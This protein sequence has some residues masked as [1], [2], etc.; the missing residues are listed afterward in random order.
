M[1]LNEMD[2]KNLAIYE[3]NGGYMSAE[4]YDAAEVAL[5]T[6][7]DGIREPFIEGKHTQICSKC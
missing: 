5:A 6:G 1:T 3:A 7:Y 2:S 4:Q